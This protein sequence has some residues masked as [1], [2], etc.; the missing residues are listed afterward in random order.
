MN[1]RRPSLS[2]K[3]PTKA[4]ASITERTGPRGPLMAVPPPPP[5]Q[6]GGSG[7]RVLGRSRGSAAPDRTSAIP[8]H[9]LGPGEWR[10]GKGAREGHGGQQQKEKGK[11]GSSGGAGVWGKRGG[12]GTGW[13]TIWRHCWKERLEPTST[14]FDGWSTTATTRNSRCAPPIARHRAGGC[15]G[16]GCGCAPRAT[17]TEEHRPRRGRGGAGRRSGGSGVRGQ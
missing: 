1:S 9:R 15:G 2:E 4:Q 6:C 7:Q 10:T 11:G 8:R 17:G 14:I 13:G 5:S 12:P 16:G 3:P